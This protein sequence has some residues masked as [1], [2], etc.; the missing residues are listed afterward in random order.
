MD[1]KLIKALM[2][3]SKQSVD[4]KMKPFI[5]MLPIERKQHDRTMREK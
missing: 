3:L 4:S 5:S 2:V 1:Q